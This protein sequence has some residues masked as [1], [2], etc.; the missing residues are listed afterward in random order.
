MEQ[1]LEFVSNH[2][3][4]ITA[5]VVTLGL[6][7]VVEVQRRIAGTR[8]IT[9]AQAVRLQNE[10]GIFLDVRDPAEYRQGHLLSAKHIPLKELAERLNELQKHKTQPIIA[11]CG[12]GGKALKACRVL[13]QNGFAKVYSIAGGLGAWVKADLPVERK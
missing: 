11:Y 13:E 6:V 5:F 4:L 1:Y 8:E 3:L 2:P 7:I 9:P 12:T 10:D